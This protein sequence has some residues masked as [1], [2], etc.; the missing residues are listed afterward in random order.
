VIPR[1]LTKKVKRQSLS[2]IFMNVNIMP[3]LEYYYDK[4]GGLDNLILDEIE[5][6]VD[7]YDGSDS[8]S[9]NLNYCVVF[10][11]EYGKLKKRKP[12]ESDRNLGQFVY[13]PNN[14]TTIGN[15][16][17]VFNFRY[18]LPKHWDMPNKFTKQDGTVVEYYKSTK[19]FNNA[20]ISGELRKENL[21]YHTQYYFTTDK[22]IKWDILNNA[23]SVFISS[24]QD[25]DFSN[26]NTIGSSRS[27]CIRNGI[28]T[29]TNTWTTDNR[30]ETPSNWN[31]NVIEKFY[32]DLNLCGRKNDYNMLEDYGCPI[33]IK[34]RS[35][36]LDNFVSGILTV[37]LNG[38]VFNESFEVSDLTTSNHKSS[39]SSYVIGYYGHGK[40][41]ILPKFS[42]TPNDDNF[43]F[44]PIQRDIIYYDFMVDDKDTMDKYNSYFGN[45]LSNIFKENKNK[46]TF[47]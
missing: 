11:D 25:I 23:K 35:V 21:P 2:N 24:N 18:N 46:Y 36:Y 4:N 26:K 27:Y 45:D 6:I 17:N 12:V 3:N 41:I 10:R 34:S 13:V 30:V 42:G 16:S 29:Y 28:L 1:N 5:D 40:N 33:V 19:D 32:V 22:S 47:K 31:N 39:G 14:F 8:D 20:I 9:D 15:I 7:I 37:F 43:V 44:I 38:R